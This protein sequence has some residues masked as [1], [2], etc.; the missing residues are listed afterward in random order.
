MLD[1]QIVFENIDHKIGL[2]IL[3]IFTW[4]WKLEKIYE[5]KRKGKTDI[6]DTEQ[7]VKIAS[8]FTSFYYDYLKQLCNY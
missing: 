6:T 4:E 2:K 5:L 1:L 7:S 8:S 3:L